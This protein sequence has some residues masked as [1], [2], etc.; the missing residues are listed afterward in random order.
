M[1]SLR[2]LEE[3]YDNKLC[4][5]DSK[6]KGLNFFYVAYTFNTIRSIDSQSLRHD[7]FLKPDVAQEYY[8]TTEL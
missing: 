4:L 8:I 6:A 2:I 7:S 1:P 5:N 3:H